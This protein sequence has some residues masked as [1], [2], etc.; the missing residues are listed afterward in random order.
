M[1][2]TKKEGKKGKHEKEQLKEGEKGKKER[3]SV[4]TRTRQTGSL[5]IRHSHNRLEKVFHAMIL[6]L[7]SL[8]LFF[9]LCDGLS[10]EAMTDLPSLFGE[11]ASIGIV[12]REKFR[13]LFLLRLISGLHLLRRPSAAA[14]RNRVVL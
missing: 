11:T 4:L 3:L 1:E 5:G 2:S 13:L 9:V 6:F 12:P 14:F 7:Q 8:G 10:D